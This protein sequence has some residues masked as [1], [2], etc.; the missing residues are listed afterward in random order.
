VDL[1][2]NLPQGTFG[3]LGNDHLIQLTSDGG[4]LVEDTKIVIPGDCS[5]PSYTYTPPN[6]NLTVSAS[7]AITCLVAVE[8]TISTSSQL[9]DSTWRFSVEVKNL[10]TRGIENIR[11]ELQADSTYF[12]VPAAQEVGNLGVG[13]HQMAYFD[14]GVK[15]TVENSP[16]TAVVTYDSQYGTFRDESQV[17][18][19]ATLP[20]SP[21]VE[22]VIASY[23][24]LILIACVVGGI[25]AAAAVLLR[26]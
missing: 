9:Q 6:P 15:Q 3:E 17:S 20:S 2:G 5:V 19:S 25:A 11:V 7:E 26:R 23:L 1:T 24:P 10:G 16:V 18:A 13:M 12:E 8:P 22:E 21:P 14:V 4:N